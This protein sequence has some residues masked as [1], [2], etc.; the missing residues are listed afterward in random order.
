MKNYITL[1]VPACRDMLMKIAMR[2]MCAV[3]GGCTVT[4]AEGGWIDDDG[5][6]VIE[7]V[8]LLKSFVSDED[9]SRL[10]SEVRMIAHDLLKEG[11]QSVMIEVNGE[12]IFLSGEDGRNG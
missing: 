5:L 2:Q 3:A 8:Y 12:A 1:Y 11:E 7:N 6:M 9:L 10:H 4:L